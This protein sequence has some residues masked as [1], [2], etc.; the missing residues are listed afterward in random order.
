MSHSINSSPFVIFVDIGATLVKIRSNSL[1]SS[2]FITFVYIC[3]TSTKIASHSL[4]SSPFIT[5]VHISATSW[6]SYNPLAHFSI[7]YR[8][9]DKL[10]M[11]CFSTLF[12]ITN[13]GEIHY[14]FIP[15]SACYSDVAKYFKSWSW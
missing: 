10:P 3:A 13:W 4:N 12:I 9:G 2:Q 8:R 6:Q 14:V 1:N 7:D 15:N 5:F 11:L